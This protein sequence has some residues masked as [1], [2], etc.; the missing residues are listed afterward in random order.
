MSSAIRM[1]DVEMNFSGGRDGSSYLALRGVNL[2]IR[3]GESTPLAC[4]QYELPRK[5]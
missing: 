4:K 2:D 5:E 3:E 1:R